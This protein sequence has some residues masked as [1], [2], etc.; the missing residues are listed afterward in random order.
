MK[1]ALESLGKA[2]ALLEPAMSAN[3]TDDEKSSLATAYLARGGIE[4]SSGHTAAAVASSR[5]GLALREDLARAAPQDGRRQMDLAQA[6]QFLAFHLEAAGQG[7]EAMQALDRQA[8]ILSERRTAEPSSRAVRRAVEQN[9]YLVGSSLARRG[10]GEEALAHFL[11]AA[12]ITASL[13]REE[14]ANAVY[15]R[16][17]GYVQTE[18]GNSRSRAGNLAEALAAYREA[19]A[20]F[21]ELARADAKSVDGLLG[22]AM[23]HHN[24]GDALNKL[25]RGEEAVAEW[26][27][28]RPSYEAIMKGSPSNVWVGGMLGDLY[29][30]LARLE[31]AESASACSF[32]RRGAEIL[33]QVS[34]AGPMPDERRVN[35]EEARKRSAGCAPAH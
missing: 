26:R 25:G 4:L 6:W 8:A 10:R 12:E 24:A 19:G 17:L 2:I 21:D 22:V 20:A 7:E 32:Y 23:S 30:E 9:R 15:L 29:V 18:I 5:R 14:P 13:R 3:P 34:A 31:P 33:E 27:A 16:D 11:E 28:A 1:G 35:L